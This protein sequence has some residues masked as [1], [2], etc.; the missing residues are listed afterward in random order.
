VL[1]SFRHYV[2][3]SFQLPKPFFCSPILA[4]GR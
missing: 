1:Y 4:V 3:A 2:L